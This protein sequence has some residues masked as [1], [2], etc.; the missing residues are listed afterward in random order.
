MYP[1]IEFFTGP[2]FEYFQIK[3]PEAGTWSGWVYGEDIPTPP[4]SETYRIYMAVKSDLTLDVRFDKARYTVG[5]NIL[6]SALVFDGGERQSDLHMSGGEP[7]VDAYVEVSILDPLNN[8]SIIPL[9]H[10]G[11]GL[12]TTTLTGFA[13]PGSYN[14]TVKALK[15]AEEPTSPDDYGVFEFYRESIHSVFVSNVAVYGEI[16]EEVYD[17]YSVLSCLPPEAFKA[18][19][20]QTRDVLLT[21]LSEV[22]L[23]I[24]SADYQG[25]VNKLEKDILDKA[26]GYF[27]GKLKND[28]IIDETAQEEVYPLIVSLLELLTEQLQKDNIETVDQTIPDTFVLYQNYP[29]PFNP[30]TTIRYE[31]PKACRVRLEIFNML[32]SKVATLV[33]DYREPG[34]YE[35]EW[36]VNSSRKQLSSGI[37]FYKLEAGNYIETRKLILLK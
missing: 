32:G 17:I 20:E 25:A 10:A 7:V 28:W 15:V 31:L 16:S 8:E 9:R 23:K 21:K 30:S 11:E 27:G 22:S 13:N 24:N 35:V 6:I 5:E 26:D 3:N 36:N 29:N 34:Y 12:Y 33:D 37:Y 1:N 14:F 2:T 18:P 4:E 19:A